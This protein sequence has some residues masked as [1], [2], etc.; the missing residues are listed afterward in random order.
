MRYVL[1]SFFKEIELIPFSEQKPDER[2]LD[3]FDFHSAVQYLRACMHDNENIHA[4]RSLLHHQMHRISLMHM[5]DQQVV[6]QLAGHLINRTVYVREIDHRMSGWGFWGPTQSAEEEKTSDDQE[7]VPETDWIEI[8][9]VDGRDKPISN[10]KIRATL[11]GGQVVEQMVD[12]QG[13]LALNEVNKGSCQ[14]VV[15]RL[16]EHLA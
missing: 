7:M 10:I 8:Q 9:L 4:M 2:Y 13:L 16:Q 3:M 12:K 14:I 1:R 6:E 11:A 15:P 5:S